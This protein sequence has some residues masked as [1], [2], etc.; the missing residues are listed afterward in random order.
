[1]RANASSFTWKRKLES[2]TNLA[3]TPVETIPE[4]RLGTGN[5][6]TLDIDLSRPT[7]RGTTETIPEGRLGAGN[8]PTLDID[9]ED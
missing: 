3:R 9:L 1:M 5:R 7:A 4:G 2:P 8:R 6:P